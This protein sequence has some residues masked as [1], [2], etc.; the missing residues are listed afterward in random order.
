MLER[1]AR[2]SLQASQQLC[3]AQ[4]MFD[5]L[6]QRENE[7]MFRTTVRR[8]DF[9]DGISR[10]VEAYRLIWN[11]FD[12]SIAYEFGFDQETLLGLTLKCAE[13]EQLELGHALGRVLDHSVAGIESKGGETISIC[14]SPRASSTSFTLALA[15]KIICPGL[16]ARAVVHK[17]VRAAGS[18]GGAFFA[19]LGY[20]SWQSTDRGPGATHRQYPM[21]DDAR[22]LADLPRSSAL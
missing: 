14:W 12:R 2:P 4:G 7:E 15:V 3:Y 13:Q 18:F 1:E 22:P 8:L 16:K 6:V 21:P 17:I 9:P 5:Y 11:W 20:Q 19:P 10:E